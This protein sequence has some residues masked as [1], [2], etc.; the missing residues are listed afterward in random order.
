MLAKRLMWILWPSFL[1]ACLME[2]VVFALVD[3]QDLHWLGHNMSISR[4]AVYTIAFFVFWLIAAAASA[5]T[6][7]LA[8]TSAGV[9]T[10]AFKDTSRVR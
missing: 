10:D 3:P 7:F 4:E 9:D 5:M 8:S 6:I 1:A 2:M